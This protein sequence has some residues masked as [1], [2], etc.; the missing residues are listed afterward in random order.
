MVGRESTQRAMG[1]EAARGISELM[2][3]CKCW[4]YVQVLGCVWVCRFCHA[5]KSYRERADGLGVGGAAPNWRR[6][7]V[8]LS[9]RK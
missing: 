8:P 2:A 7:R 4:Y 9:V 1:A 5:L 6:G 3:T